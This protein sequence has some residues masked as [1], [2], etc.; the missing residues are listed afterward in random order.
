MTPEQEA[1]LKKAAELFS[2]AI[3][4]RR[5]LINRVAASSPSLVMSRDDGKLYE[6]ATRHIDQ[7]A[8]ECGFLLASLYLPNDWLVDVPSDRA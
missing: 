7:A 5:A 4:A 6:D 8:Q 2:V 3:N 1:R